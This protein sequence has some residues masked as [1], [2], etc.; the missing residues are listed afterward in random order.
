MNIDITIKEKLDSLLSKLRGL[1]KPI[2]LFAVIQ[3]EDMETWDL[4]IGGENI[5]NKENLDLV[6]RI[7][8]QTFDESEIIKIPRL[9][10]LDSD[11]PIIISIN[12][13]FSIEGG[14]TRIENI[15][16]NNFFIKNAYLLYSKSIH[17]TEKEEH[18]Q[19][20][21]KQIV[22]KTLTSSASGNITRKD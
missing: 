4:L 22:K 21:K 8:R 12:K 3:R 18:Y 10:L 11:H 1:G 19:E 20:Q 15:K 16:I 13:A 9:V 17:R 7:I 6:A 5:R 2:S 14:V